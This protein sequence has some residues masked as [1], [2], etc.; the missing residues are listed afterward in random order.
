MTYNRF[1]R[2]EGKYN[3]ANPDQE[4]WC[5]TFVLRPD[6]PVP[7]NTR[8]YTTKPGDPAD[9]REDDIPALEL[10]LALRRHFETYLYAKS[11][12]D[13]LSI[14]IPYLEE[15]ADQDAKDKRL[16][17]IAHAYQQRDQWQRVIDDLESETDES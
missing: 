10:A 9:Y 12:L 3:W 11:D 2:S 4:Q 5:W 7:M 13:S 6:A 8:S 17:N 15:W 1:R 14:L 16:A